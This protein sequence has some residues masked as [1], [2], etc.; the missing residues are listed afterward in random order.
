MHGCVLSRVGT[1]TT[2][3]RIFRAVLYQNAVVVVASYGDALAGLVTAA[4]DSVSERIAAAAPEGTQVIKAV[5]TQTPDQQLQD[6]IP[7]RSGSGPRHPLLVQVTPSRRH[8]QKECPAG[9]V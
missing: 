6:G 8:R 5:N 4:G 7:S 9:S 3:S 2:T 1:P